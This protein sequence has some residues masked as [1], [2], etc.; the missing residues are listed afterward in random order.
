MNMLISRH[1]GRGERASPV[2]FLHSSDERGK[3]RGMEKREKEREGEGGETGKACVAA[4]EEREEVKEGERRRAEKENARRR[5]CGNTFMKS[6][7]FRQI[8]IVAIWTAASPC[9]A[10][11]CWRQMNHPC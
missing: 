5:E 7:A 1:A 3:E 2:L 6:S 10:I 8:S 4:G 11:L 9:C